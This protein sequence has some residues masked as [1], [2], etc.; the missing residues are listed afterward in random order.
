MSG[1]ALAIKFFDKPQKY[2]RDI[3]FNM[4]DELIDAHYLGKFKREF[5]SFG[6]R[7]LYPLMEKDDI[8]RGPLRDYR[9]KRIRDEVKGIYVQRYIEEDSGDTQRNLIKS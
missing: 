9:L 4:C 1:A 5:P 8:P 2:T 3:V 6:Y 7:T